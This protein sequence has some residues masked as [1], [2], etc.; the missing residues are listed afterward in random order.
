MAKQVTTGV[1]ETTW[2][3]KD[4]EDGSALV[5]N[6]PIRQL[7]VEADGKLQKTG[8]EDFTFLRF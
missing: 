3:Y 8:F 1:F 5:L 4:G 6:R 2:L 7:K